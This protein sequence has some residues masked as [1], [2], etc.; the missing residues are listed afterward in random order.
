M[1]TTLSRIR[2]LST[3]QKIII[4]IP[5]IL[6]VSTVII[7]NNTNAFTKNDT[8]TKNGVLTKMPI[9]QQDQTASVSPFIFG[10]NMDNQI[11]TSPRAQ[12]LVKHLGLRTIRLGDTSNAKDL[13]K[14]YSQAQTIKNMGLIPL[15]ILHGGGIADPGQLLAIDTDMVN[16]IQQIFGGPGAKVRL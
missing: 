7:M 1:K 5:S 3:T 12:I 11:S 16:K 2:Q 10:T 13:A 6:L 4:L 14:F 15:I 9:V 8:L